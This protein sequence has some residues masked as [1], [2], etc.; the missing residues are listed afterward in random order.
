NFWSALYTIEAAVPDMIR[1]G[2]GR[3]VNITS[4]GG[5]ISVPHLLPYCASK[6]ALVGLSEGLHAELKRLGITVTTVVPGLMR[7]GSP[8]NADFKGQHRAEFTWFNISDTL[9]VISMSAEAAARQIICA[10]KRGDAEVILSLPAMFGIR[11]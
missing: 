3:I 7:T 6:F 5:K 10:C 9:P 1:R 2:G 11:F 4:I 8:R